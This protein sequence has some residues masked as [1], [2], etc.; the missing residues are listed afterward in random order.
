MLTEEMLREQAGEELFSQ[1]R[2]I[3]HRALVKEA[4]RT[5]DEIQYLVSG[6]EK[7]TVTVTAGAVRCDCGKSMCPH[8]I[9]AVLTALKSG[10]MQDME[11]RRAQA[12]VPALF[13]AV[14]GMLPEAD[15][16]RLAVSLFLTREGLRIGLKIGEDRL[17][18]VRHIPHF[19]TC[20]A[21]GQALSFGKG[22]EYRPQWMRFDEKQ[23]RL[24]DV[25]S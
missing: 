12:A 20:R 18:V 2:S 14:A 9:A 7:H 21:E 17:Y 6:E 3:F 8:G 11:K 16:I 4:R 19:L 5:K 25:L 10:A 15:G 23:A 13:D 1:G 24:L 22:F